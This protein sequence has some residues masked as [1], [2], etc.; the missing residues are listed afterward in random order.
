MNYGKLN[1]DIYERSVVKVIKTSAKECIQFYDGAEI[2]DFCAIFP[3]EQI[4]GLVSAQATAGGKNAVLRAYEAALNV[5]AAR[6][7]FDC[8]DNKAYADIS[9]F[10]PAKT[11][12]IKVREMLAEAARRADQ[13]RIPIGNV[14]VQIMPW[15]G[16]ETA[17][18]VVYT[19]LHD[20]VKR[21]GAAPGDDIVMTKWIGLEGTALIAR[22]SFDKLKTHYPTDLVENAADFL[23]YLSVMPEAATAVKSGASYLQAA[24]EGG[25]FGG[26]WE[27]AA[28]NN[29]GLVVDLKSIPVR[30][31]TVEVCEY[32]DFNPYELMAGGSLLIT[33]PNGGD[34]VKKL[35]DCGIFSAVIGKITKGND[36]L[37]CHEGENRFLEPVRGD[38]IYRYYTTPVS[39]RK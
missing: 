34:L 16:M 36:R 18:C 29:V 3:C 14:N 10:I 31:E 28:N 5:I 37:I 8:A 27:L 23:K 2:G 26:L 30:Q 13:L 39:W 25:I 19:A 32:F 17:N 4:N 35:A 9:L 20:W 7:A 24:R 12:E 33:C 1:E 15:V 38:E 22:S 21:K 6:G 11:R